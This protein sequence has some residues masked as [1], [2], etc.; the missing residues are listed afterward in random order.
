MGVGVKSTFSRR[1]P[2]KNCWFWSLKLYMNAIFNLV[3][4]VNVIEN[5][6]Q[7]EKA[8]KWKNTYSLKDSVQLFNKLGI[9]SVLHWF[10]QESLQQ[11]ET[12]HLFWLF[13]F[14]INQVHMV[15]ACLQTFTFR[16]PTVELLLKLQL[17]NC[18]KSAQQCNRVFV[19]VLVFHLHLCGFVEKER[20]IGLIIVSPWHPSC[21]DESPSSFPPLLTPSPHPLLGSSRRLVFSFPLRCTNSLLLPH[22]YFVPGPSH[23]GNTLHGSLRSIPV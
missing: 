7:L 17:S 4:R 1:P 13:G 12:L 21:A 19:F 18:R 23:L 14:I 8:P 10:S 22:T 11:C 2:R 5:E 9:E 3:N 20:H 15:S 16:S 6:L